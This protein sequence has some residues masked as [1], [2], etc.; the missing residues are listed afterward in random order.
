MPQH[1]NMDEVVARAKEYEFIRDSHDP[2]YDRVL[3]GIEI[4]KE[5]I[6]TND[7]V[8]YG[9]QGL[10]MALRLRG[11]KIYP[12]EA[13]PD[14]DFYSPR[15]VEH[16]YE[17]A[18]ILYHAGFTGAAAIRAR[19]VRTMRI[20][21]GGGHV[22]AD[23]TYYPAE[24]FA[25]LPT[26]K[27]NGMRIV[28]P[29]YQ[30][31]DMH[32]SLSHPF[33]NP[34]QEVIFDR[35]SKDIRRFNQMNAHYPVECDARPELHE[36]SVSVAMHRYVMGGWA[37]YALIYH[38]FVE[39]MAVLTG[40]A[41][42]PVDEFDAEELDEDDED[43]TEVIDG[44]SELSLL[45]FIGGSATK[46][47]NAKRDSV[48]S[49]PVILSRPSLSVV[50]DTFTFEVPAAGA[51]FDIVS[52]DPE[53]HAAEIGMTDIVAR[54]PY[55]SMI[56]PTLTGK[57]L[58]G[59]VTARIVSSRGSLVSVNIVKVAGVNFKVS[60]TQLLMKDLAALYNTTSDATF[61]AHYYSLLSMIATVEAAVGDRVND[62][63]IYSLLLRSPLFPSIYTYG[64]DNHSLA[65]LVNINKI[66]SELGE[67]TEHILPWNYY[68]ERMIPKGYAWPAWNA[69][70]SHYFRE[71]G[72][73]VSRAEFAADDSD[74]AAP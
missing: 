56:P 55:V 30:R 43:N 36:V 41:P 19:Y 29:I 61:I 42:V 2:E 45:E 14:L 52:L 51:E 17:L 74:E 1:Y 32:N 31:I 69:T 46:R 68:P 64:G 60:N 25:K 34:P 73:V 12:D 8:L 38:H 65:Y 3:A 21:V 18:D 48:S 72:A 54:E 57:I 63:D 49:T 33:D 35:W 28:H 37:A 44:S 71:S 9:G 22:I 24:L 15:S 20:D 39:L 47:K 23:I 58:D 4:V 7:L 6:I 10:D 59:Q 70:S 40:D 26:L 53:K 16:A 5:F 13:I 62:P 11:D 67:A 27:Y 50:A 66:K